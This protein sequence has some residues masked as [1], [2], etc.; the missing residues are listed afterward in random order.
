LIGI[1]EPAY[2]MYNYHKYSYTD[3]DSE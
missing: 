3:Y 2:D 1:P